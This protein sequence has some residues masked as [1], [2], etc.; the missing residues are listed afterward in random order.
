MPCVKTA[1]VKPTFRTSRRDAN[2]VS[3][4]DSR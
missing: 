3:S 1:D 4:A 2:A